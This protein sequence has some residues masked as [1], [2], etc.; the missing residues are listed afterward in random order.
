MKVLALCLTGLIFQGAPAKENPSW[1]GQLGVIRTDL[2]ERTYSTDQLSPLV[3]IQWTRSLTPRQGFRAWGEFA[4]LRWRR[5]SSYVREDLVGIPENPIPYFG[6]EREEGKLDSV[7]VG[8]DYRFQFFPGTTSPY[9]F[10]GIVETRFQNASALTR[11]QSRLAKDD[12]STKFGISFGIGFRF[13]DQ[14]EAEIRFR[15]FE[16]KGPT[17]PHAFVSLSVGKTFLF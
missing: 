1:S 12:V 13:Q 6:Y 14:F 9:V 4:H 10:A 3:G 5:E 8:L 2:G 15:A 11:E 17:Y 7:S 16:I